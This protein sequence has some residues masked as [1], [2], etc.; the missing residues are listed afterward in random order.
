MIFMLELLEF[1]GEVGVLL[2]KGGVYELEGGEGG[3][4]VVML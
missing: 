3:E 2:G 4:E 1:E